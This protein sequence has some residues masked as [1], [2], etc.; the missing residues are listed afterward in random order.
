MDVLTYAMARKAKGGGTG[1][2]ARSWHDLKDRPFYDE[3]VVYYEY[4]DGYTPL[5]SFEEEGMFMYKVSDTPLTL[6]ELVGTT[7]GMV[8]DGE[9]ILI[10]TT[11][12]DWTA[13]NDVVAHN[14]LPVFSALNDTE[15]SGLTLTRGLWV[16][17]G[18]SQYISK[19]YKASTKKLDAKFLPDGVPY[20][21]RKTET[22]L[23]EITFDGN[24]T[25]IDALEGT[26]RDGSDTEKLIVTLDGVVYEVERFE[27]PYDP[28]T[29]WGDSRLNGGVAGNDVNPID[30]PFVIEAVLDESFGLG[31]G[32]GGEI[33]SWSILLREDSTDSS[34]T[35]KI[36][37]D[38]GTEYVMPDELK[39]AIDERI[40]AIIDDALG[41]EY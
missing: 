41:G 22:F 26:P 33:I 30:V 34:H 17:Y 1:G 18:E 40:N 15:E 21:A 13:Y 19:A 31:V 28:I 36:E 4:V 37:I 9:E 8:S 3:S 16:L 32:F 20:S 12:N 2:G 35:L 29:G 7:I 14:D 25:T 24:F 27:Y 23:G 5:D 6:D 11:E 10:E 39:T 38:G